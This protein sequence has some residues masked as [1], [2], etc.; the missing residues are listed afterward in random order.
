MFSKSFLSII[1]FFSFLFTSDVVPQAVSGL[2]PSVVRMSILT[3]DGRIVAGNGVLV[4]RDGVI[5]LPWHLIRDAKKV[6]ARFP[7]GETYECSGIIDKDET[8]NAALVRIKVFG[9]P[10]LKMEAKEIP[11]GG[12]LF[13]SIF[14]DDSFGTIS[15]TAGEVR[16]FDG[17][18]HISIAEEIPVGNSGSPVTDGSG[19][20]VGIISMRLIDEKPFGFILPVGSWLALDTSL[21]T[22]PWGRAD[23]TNTAPNPQPSPA[24]TQSLEEMDD[25]IGSAL[26]VLSDNLDVI[27]W[28]DIGIKGFGFKNGV[29]GPVYEFQQQMDGIAAKLAAAQA[30]DPLRQ[31]LQKSMLQAMSLQKGSS[32]NFIRAVVIGQQMGSWGAQ[33]LDAHNRATAIRTSVKDLLIEI[34]PDIAKLESASVRFKS[35]VYPGHRYLLGIVKRPS[36]YSLGVTSYA[37][38]PLFLLVVSFTGLGYKIG[39]RPGDTIKS[40]AGIDFSN[41]WDIED[42]KLIIKQNL[43]KKVDAVV[44]RDNKEQLIRLKIPGEIPSD[45][46]YTQN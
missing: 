25:L 2:L 45:A 41:S 14:K 11:A 13:A 32:E 7:D 8:R 4:I 35:F 33:S 44:I 9:R 10:W 42:V 12:R 21:P 40:V 5:A 6:T 30:D 18:K 27:E 23:V 24:A 46:L 43:G 31:K 3:N 29:P 38:R 16:T 39:L 1:L 28:A 15:I 36:G 34:G 17:H 19:V 22:Q 20:L 37:R 26:V